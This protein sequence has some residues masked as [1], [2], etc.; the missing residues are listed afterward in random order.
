MRLW[1]KLS[2]GQ[3]IRWA[4]EERQLTQVEVANRVGLTQATVSNWVTDTS[5]KPSGP[6][7]LKLANALG[8]SPDWIVTGAGDPFDVSTV[9]D[10]G[11]RELLSLYR[12]MGPKERA[13]LI[14]HA[15]SVTSSASCPA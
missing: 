12:G 15:R 9:W 13:S 10:K 11:E 14:R 8:I 7:L 4:I 5:R 3:R 6:S 2:I 1:K